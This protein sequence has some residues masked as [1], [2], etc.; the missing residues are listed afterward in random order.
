MIKRLLVANRGEIAR[1]VLRTCRSLGIETVAVFSDVDADADFAREAD[2]AVGLGGNTPAESYLRIE[3][4]VDAIRRTGADAVHPGYGFLAENAVFA[5]A[6]IDAGAIFVGPTPEVIEA[7]GSK[8][9]ARRRMSEAGVPLLPGAE[10]SDLDDKAVL[11]AVSDLGYPLLIKASAGGGGR[12]MR[13]VVEPNQLL[14]AV[15]AARREAGAAFGDDAV[16]AE[17]YLAPFRHVEVQIFGDDS[18]HVVHLHERECSIQRRHQ[19][20]IEEAPCPGLDEATRQSLH[21]AAV[22]AAQA[23]GYTNAGTVEFLLAPTAR[24]D[25]HG[26]EFFFLEM[27]T[28]LQVEHPVTECV[29]GLDLVDLQ[30]QVAAGGELPQQ[31]V[32]GPPAGHAIEARLY[33]EDPTRDYLPSTGRVHALQ[34]P[35]EVRLDAAFDHA[36]TVSQYYDPLIAKVVAQAPNRVMAARRLATALARSTIAGIRTNRELLVRTL[37]H[38][39]FIGGAADSGFLERNPPK[40][41]GAPLITGSNVGRY[42]AAAGLA[43]Q[44]RNRAESS[45]LPGVSSGFRNVPNQPQQISFGV[46]GM[47]ISVEYQFENNRLVA[48]AVDGAVQERPVLWSACLS[49]VDLSISGIRQRFEVGFHDPWITVTGPEGVLDLELA[50]RFAEP[51]DQVDAGSLVAAMPGTIVEVPVQ[52]GDRV[53]A[54]TTLMVM[55]AMK[56]ELA[57]TAP[58][59]GVVRAL[60]VGVGAAV[61]AGE[62]LVLVD[63]E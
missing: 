63:E 50:P 37:R 14:D 1:R 24:G 43:I 6:V 36:G 32:I 57:L 13:V 18:G 54:G 51:E 34:V 11:A 4:I 10:L 41:L 27:N 15:L 40:L 9:E 39:E 55:E 12:G 35:G 7:M 5:R 61:S 45:V 2:T 52:V 23:I 25:A 22:Q 21:Q 58:A 31:S 29:L 26:E 48:L 46:G 49:A 59:D 3:T 38:E 28:R 60:A 30:L 62:V 44:A 53:I 16:Y 47:T 33:A 19:K 20:I 8:L 17:R 56:M 42:V